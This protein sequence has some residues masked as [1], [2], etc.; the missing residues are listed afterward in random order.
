MN[1]IENGEHIVNA[2]NIN[3]CFKGRYGRRENDLE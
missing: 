1:V 2:I 3:K